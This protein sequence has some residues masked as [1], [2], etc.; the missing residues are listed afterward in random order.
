MRKGKD[1]IGVGVGAII[2]NKEGKILVIRRG[3]KAKNEV[4]LWGIPGGAVEF[5][6]S[7]EEA[8]KR[9]V[10]EEL[11]IKIKPLKILSMVNHIIKKEKQ[12]WVTASFICQLKSGSPEIKEKGKV[13][14]IEWISFKDLDTKKRLSPPAVEALREVKER[15]NEI[16]DFF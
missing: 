1:Y 2:F 4:G 10:L 6:E 9:E 3:S 8:I 16:E 5:N 11:G 7:L 12:H 14:K 15:L 13:D